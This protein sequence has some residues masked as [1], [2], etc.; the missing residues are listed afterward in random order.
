MNRGSAYYF[1]LLIMMAAFAVISL[2]LGLGG[3]DR[4]VAEAYIKQSSLQPL[5]ESGVLEACSVLNRL[6]AANG[7]QAL[8]EL[9]HDLPGGTQGYVVDDNTYGG[10]FLPDSSFAKKYFERVEALTVDSLQR[11]R[12]LELSVAGEASS[13]LVEA[14]ISVN[15]HQPSFTYNVS[16][17][18]QNLTKGSSLKVNGVIKAKPPRVLYA[19]ESYEWRDDSL[20]CHGITAGGRVVMDDNSSADSY[21]EDTGLA[22]DSVIDSSVE[23]GE[24]G[25][26]LYQ[27]II[28]VSLIS[29]PKIFISHGHMQMFASTDKN[30]FDGVVIASGDV[31]VTGVSFTGAVITQG[32]V[33]LEDSRFA[34]D[35]GALFKIKLGN[36]NRRRLYDFL[37]LTKF[38][39]AAIGSND[40]E[41]ILGALKLSGWSAIDIDD[42][43]YEVASVK[44]VG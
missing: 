43:V 8:E 9:R 31:T 20:Y 28:D 24:L 36:E 27:E 41:E 21:S 5:A 29:E 30:T 17:K 10:Y 32:S 33:T 19:H 14:E 25:S 39:D 7:I 44:K 18:A 42:V 34:S 13:F 26:T 1:V 4:L 38:K 11:Y 12:R 15:G 22:I 3:A 16:S 23:L 35:R 37:R 2:L 6:A 40:A